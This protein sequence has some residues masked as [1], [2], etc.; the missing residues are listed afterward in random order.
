[1]ATNSREA[2]RRKILERGSDRLAFIT[3]QINGVSPPPPSDST[4]SLSQ[5]LL[6]SLPDTIPPPNQILNTQEIGTL[7]PS[8]PYYHP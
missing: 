1:M 6:Q 5:S 3:G 7:S 2:R 8:R 4:S